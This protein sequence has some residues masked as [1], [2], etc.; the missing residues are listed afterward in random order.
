MIDLH[1]SSLSLS[2]VNAVV[3]HETIHH[4]FLPAYHHT[5][6]MDKLLV[7]YIP[8]TNMDTENDGLEKV[9]SLNFGYLC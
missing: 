1:S 2:F 4:V 8:E 9:D 3:M 7:F 6:P 5:G